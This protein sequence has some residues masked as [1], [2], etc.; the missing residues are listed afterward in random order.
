[1]IKSMTGFGRGKYENE[2]RTYTV[3]IKSVNHKYSD[4]NVRLPR[5]LN[6]VED[7]IRKRVAEVIS[8]GKI[9]IFVSFENYSSKGT[10]IRINKELAKEY[11]KELKSLAEEA[12]L[13]FDLS[14]IDVSKFPE[15]LKLEDEDNDELIG[16]E[17]M[18]ALDD[19]LEKFVSMR[20]VEGQKLVEDIERRIYLIQDKVNE[21][22]KFSSTLV[23]EYMT[24]LQTRVNELLAP[25][26]VDETRLM[27]EIVI[28]S[29]KSSIEEELTRLKSHISQFLE[30][31]KQSSP[32]GKK[33]DFLIQEINREV[34]T[35]GSKAN[36]L[37]ITN[38]VIE[39]K[40]EVENIREQI[41]NIE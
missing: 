24:R 5:F 19:A 21:V 8:R 9:D 25:G 16:Q 18:I 35:I 29:D 32:I 39:I 12:D 33:I 34:N 2:G 40:T 23:E 14:V 15:I 38:K 31:I 22:T 26:T 4:I 1:M 6:S 3:E 7:K 36:S 13:R 30:L 37:D 10:T 17:V 27:Q 11:I 28:F 20:E 41:Q